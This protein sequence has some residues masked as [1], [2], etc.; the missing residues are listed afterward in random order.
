MLRNIIKLF[1]WQTF[2]RIGASRTINRVYMLVL[3]L[4]IAIQLS[5]FF[6]IASIGLWIDQLY[7]GAVGQLATLSSVYKGV[8][9]T[10]LLVSHN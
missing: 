1:G 3:V 10:V 2:K 5:L 8:L 7:N 4:S 6:I 9:I